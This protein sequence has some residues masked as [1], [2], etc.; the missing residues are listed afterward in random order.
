MAKYEVDLDVS[1]VL[2]KYGF[3]GVAAFA[4][5]LLGIRKLAFSH[6]FSSICRSTVMCKN[7]IL[8]KDAAS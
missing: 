6:V 4:N 7:E 1:I 5:I 2:S 3:I 8:S